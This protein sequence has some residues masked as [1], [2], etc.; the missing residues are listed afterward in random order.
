MNIN[1]YHK[2]G[3]LENYKVKEINKKIIIRIRII[4]HL[5][6]EVIS[7]CV[8]LLYFNKTLTK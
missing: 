4:R 2:T 3:D 1:V 6:L 5:K 8:Y 7:L